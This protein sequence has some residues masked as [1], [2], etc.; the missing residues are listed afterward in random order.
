MLNVD[1]RVAPVSSPVAELSLND[2]LGRDVIAWT[3]PDQRPCPIG[4]G[5]ARFPTR[6]SISRHQ[7]QTSASE[8]LPM[9]VAQFVWWIRRACVLD[10]PRV[11]V[12]R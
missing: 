3:E 5:A 1:I 8:E 7:H 6:E 2:A 9:A 10:E 4:P 12:P 11:T